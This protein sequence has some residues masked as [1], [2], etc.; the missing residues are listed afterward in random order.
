M[1]VVARVTLVNNVAQSAKYKLNRTRPVVIVFLSVP[2][3]ISSVTS[4]TALFDCRTVLLL[5]VLVVVLLLALLLSIPSIRCCLPGIASPKVGT[6][7]RNRNHELSIQMREGSFVASLL[8]FRMLAV[9]AAG[10]VATSC[11]RRVRKHV[12]VSSAAVSSFGH[13]SAIVLVSLRRLLC[14]DRTK[15]GVSV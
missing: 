4:Q 8:V 1:T 12:M 2:N 14:K 6:K 9:P 5:P 15:V 10:A 7:L 13:Q 3:R 11:C